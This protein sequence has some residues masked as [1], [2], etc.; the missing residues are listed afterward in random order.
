LD[1]VEVGGIG[2]EH[3]ALSP[4]CGGCD[5]LIIKHPDR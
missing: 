1:V 4:P 3:T 2:F 5:V